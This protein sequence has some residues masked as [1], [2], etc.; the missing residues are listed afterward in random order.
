MY[1]T[2]PPFTIAEQQ[3]TKP[4]QGKAVGVGHNRRK[5]S[6]R[7]YRKAYI[8]NIPINHGKEWTK[9]NDASLLNYKKNKHTIQQI[10]SYMGRTEYAIECR[11]IYLQEKEKPI[12]TRENAKKY[13]DI[14][15][16]FTKGE[17]I[18][19]LSGN[20]WLPITSFMFSKPIENY[21]VQPKWYRVAKLKYNNNFLY[22]DIAD[23][24]ETEENLENEERFVCW[25]T[26]RIEYT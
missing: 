14:L 5:F 19:V 3:P 8:M 23:S 4:L 1:K 26:E 11:L 6:N 15:H 18:E 21:R 17:K 24:E 22:T 12:I 13:L 7:I 9:Q 16:A 2:T 20:T 10:A 25:L